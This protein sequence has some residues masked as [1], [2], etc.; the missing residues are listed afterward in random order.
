MLKSAATAKC[1]DVFTSEHPTAENF[2]SQDEEA[3]T[4]SLPSFAAMSAQFCASPDSER[5]TNSLS[6]LQA[7]NPCEQIAHVEI[8][9]RLKTETKILQKVW[10]QV[11]L[12]CG[13]PHVV[14][15]CFHLLPSG[16][17]VRFALPL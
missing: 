8:A 14:C 3:A 13:G 5:F 1:S 2:S 10:Y 6:C 9:C 7:D 15:C 11:S 4:P 12:L 16:Y 17:V